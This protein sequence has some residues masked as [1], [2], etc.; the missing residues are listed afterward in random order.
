MIGTTTR[1]LTL[2][3]DCV[4]AIVGTWPIC[5]SRLEFREPQRHSVFD[6]HRQAAAGPHRIRRTKEPDITASLAADN[7]GI[8][9][10]LR[11]VN[12]QMPL[13]YFTLNMNQQP[14]AAIFVSGQTRMATTESVA[15]AYIS[16]PH[17]ALRRTDTFIL[18]HAIMISKSRATVKRV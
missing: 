1:A 10:L 5:H 16:D 14:N 4:L 11:Y 7:G 3:T 18:S 8:R 9:P 13:R 2:G 6:T 12:V 15:A 17:S